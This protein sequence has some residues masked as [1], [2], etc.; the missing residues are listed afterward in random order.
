MA[1]DKS[2]ALIQF[3][4]QNDVG[5]LAQLLADG[6]AIDGRDQQGRTALL[7]ATHAGSID[8]ARFLIEQGADVNLKDNI[9]DSAYLYAAAEGPLEILEMTLI[10]G[11]DLS[12]VNRYGGTGLIPAAH[13]G[14]ID[15]VRAL[16]NT[17][18]DVDHVNDPGWTALMEA[19]ILGD[20]GPVYIEI[21]GL[22]LN[23]G[24]DR[25]ITDNEGQ[26]PLDHAE[27]RQFSEIARLLRQ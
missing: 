20:G 19:V 22:L 15:I 12:S 26:T 24:A 2:E 21:V 4:S 14:H 13:H 3:A 17:D 27:S 6:A 10:A 9:E 8:A 7:A 18:I 5:R 23:A 25:S 1:D 11:A 16:L